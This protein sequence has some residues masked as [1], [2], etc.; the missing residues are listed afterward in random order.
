MKTILFYGLIAILFTIS[1][2]EEQTSQTLKDDRTII[3]DLTIK[4]NECLV[5]KDIN[6]LT[7]IYA[8]TV[9]LYGISMVNAEAVSNKEKFFKTTADFTQSITSDITVLKH[10]DQQYKVSFTKH[11]IFNGKPTDVEGRLT[12]DKINGNWKITNESDDVS[13]NKP[14]PPVESCLDI[15][16]KIV[17]SSQLYHKKTKGLQDAV[18]KN[19]GTGFGISLESSPDP[20]S[21]DAFEFS[22]T[23]DFSLH[24]SYPDRVVVIARF[25]FNPEEN[26]LYEYD[27]V[28]DAY[29]PI[30][31]D[32]S[33]LTRFEK[34]CK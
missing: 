17:T 7:T 10:T 32:K 27:W 11:T 3:E 18:I 30:D 25:S 6:T 29:I 5:K 23:Y 4:W 2:K 8:D 9:S 33:L 19:G 28:E 1:C 20:E 14:D 34:I 21:D 26:L 31:F 22:D 24:E 16:M 13:D 15:V 12:F